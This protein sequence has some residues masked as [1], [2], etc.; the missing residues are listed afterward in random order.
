MS[1][2]A[3]SSLGTFSKHTFPPIKD[4]FLSTPFGRS[5]PGSHKAALWMMVVD[6]ISL[7]AALMIAL[8]LALDRWLWPGET[9]SH[10]LLSSGTLYWQIGYMV[11][12]SIVLLL[13]AHHYGLYGR[14][15]TCSAFDEQRR[16]V[17]CCLTSGLLLCG[18][19]F[20]TH[21]VAISRAAIAYLISFTT[22]F[23]CLSRLGWR[24]LASRRYERGLDTRNV[25][26]VGASSMGLAFWKEIQQHRYLGR[27]CLGFVEIPN[28]HRLAQIPGDQ[29]LGSMDQLGALARQHFV[30]EFIIADHCPASVTFRLVEIARECEIEVLASPGLC[31]GLTHERR[32]EYLGGFPVISIHRRNERLVASLI[33]RAV[34]VLFSSIMLMVLLPLLTAIAIW[35]SLDSQ[36]PIFYASERIGKK[37]RVFRCF[38]FRT[39][40]VDA[41]QLKAA[42][43]S[44]NERRGIL[45]KIKNDPR[46]TRVGRVLR[47]YSLDELPQLLNVFRGEMSLVGPRPPI[48]SEV[49]EYELEHLRRLEVLP[50]LTGLWQVSA[51][52]DPSF[53]KYVELDIT[54]VE[55]WSIWL[56]MKILMQTAEVVIRGTGS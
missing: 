50:G 11:W 10:A 18:A 1:R 41:D 22:L 28:N 39:M 34:D 33:K 38:K 55:N 49:K 47:K 16:A 20:V 3:T 25:I 2:M 35:I 9:L 15:L 19:I 32:P 40:V 5:A 23:F 42:L 53:E 21:N 44:Q 56:D 48:A 36:G 45:F 52:Q 12:F 24:Y 6:V 29:I 26:V 8:P 17:Q 37:G 14:T 51:R 30:D 54:Y 4:N 13:V 46:I 43:A 31:D 27:V 7:A